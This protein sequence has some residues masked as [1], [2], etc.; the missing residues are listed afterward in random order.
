[1]RALKMSLCI[2]PVVVTGYGLGLKFGPAG[3]ALGCSTAMILLVVPIACYAIRD[4][5]ITLMVSGASYI[6]L[7]EVCCWLGCGLPYRLSVAQQAY[8]MCS[9]SFYL[10]IS[11]APR[12]GR[13]YL[14]NGPCSHVTA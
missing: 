6:K 14:G 9:S 1:M 5:I 3:V 2:V 11:C 10:L 12:M 8:V 13:S 7:V 4:T